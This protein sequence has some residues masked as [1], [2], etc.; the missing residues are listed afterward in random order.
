MNMSKQ[1]THNQMPR[2]A[3]T[4]AGI[5]SAH[6]QGIPGFTQALLAGKSKFIRSERFPEL[7]FP[8]IVAALNDF[9]FEKAL[10]N[11]GDLSDEL[12]TVAHK[13]GR[14]APL[15]IQASLI[16]ALEAWQQAKLQQ[17]KLESTRIGLVVAGNNTTQ[18]YQYALQPIFRQNPSYLSPTY[19]L[20]FM[21]TDQVGILSEVFGIQGEGFTV[22]GA[23]ASGNMGIIH[24]QRLIQQRLVDVCLVVGTLAD[25]S[26]LELQGFYNIGALGGDNF[27]DQP[28]KAC[29]PFDRDHGGFIWGQASGCLVIESLEKVQ[30]SGVP[31][32]AEIAGSA[33]VLD[34]Y[35]GT[36]TNSQGESRAMQNALSEAN[37]NSNQ[38]HYLNAHGSSSAL[39]DE[40]EV[41]AIRAVFE[42]SIHHL[43]LNSTKSVLGHCLW[44]AGVVEAIATLLQM[45][46]NFVHANLNLENPIDPQCRFV[47]QQSEVAVIQNAMSNSFG[48]GGINT[49]IIFTRGG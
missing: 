47:G 8:V 12:L 20:H 32:W 17:R 41:Q 21:D 28:N 9:T 2:V 13:S 4:G 33:I 3:I 11:Y 16:A 43:W 31:Y 10:Q 19:A 25:L 14:R 26:P 15:T 30:E 49:S 40:V 23:T 29:R 34:G 44:S 42:K 36:K 45:R 46:D 6:G 5:L 39:G 27:Q 48:F 24:G 1:R 38:I 7:S 37:M 22:G 18:N 35:R